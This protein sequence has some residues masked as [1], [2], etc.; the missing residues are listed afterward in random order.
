[1]VYETKITSV[2]EKPGDIVYVNYDLIKGKDVVESVTI[3]LEGE[4]LKNQ[5]EIINRKMAKKISRKIAVDEELTSIKS[6]EGNSYK[7]N[8]DGELKKVKKKK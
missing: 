8:N 1:M 7:L 3:L 5:E 2:T 6:L 4:D